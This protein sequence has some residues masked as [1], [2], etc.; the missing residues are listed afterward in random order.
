MHPWPLV[1]AS[2]YSKKTWG[3][4]TLYS[5][6]TMQGGSG[7]KCCRE[8]RV[9][10]AKLVFDALST[11]RYTQG[12]ASDSWPPLNL[13]LWPPAIQKMRTCTLLGGY[14]GGTDV[15]LAGTAISCI[16]SQL[17]ARPTSQACT[18]YLQC[19]PGHGELAHPLKHSQIDER[20][21]QYNS[22]IYL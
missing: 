9:P 12:N 1:Q 4:A 2:S 8:I 18:Q 11:R 3:K 21:S 19:V 22:H 6:D 14:C 10:K 15:I 17:N 5:G 16:Y 13:Q 7:R 20:A